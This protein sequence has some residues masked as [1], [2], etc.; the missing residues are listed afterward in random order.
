LYVLLEGFVDRFVYLKTGLSL[1][2]VFI[3]A[4]LLLLDI[5]KIPTALSL[6][7]V[8]TI[9]AISVIASILKTQNAPKVLEK[10]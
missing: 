9:L 4:K 5:F 6:V 10:A 2:L 3:G 1:I 8:V 7:V